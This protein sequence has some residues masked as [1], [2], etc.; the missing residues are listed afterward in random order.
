MP[1]VPDLY[2]TSINTDS[3]D[4]IFYLSSECHMCEG[5]TGKGGGGVGVE[6]RSSCKR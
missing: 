5:T 6:D 3:K 1:A 4:S 2:S